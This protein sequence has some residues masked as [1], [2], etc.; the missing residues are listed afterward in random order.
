MTLNGHDNWVRSILFHPCGKFLISS[1]DDATIRVWDLTRAKL[2]KKFDTAHENFI[3][4]LDWSTTF[5]ALASAGVDQQIKIWD[6][7]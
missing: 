1:S 5:P 2:H 3:T 7:K 4:T 6:L